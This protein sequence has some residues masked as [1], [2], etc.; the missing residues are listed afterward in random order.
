MDASEDI[1]HDADDYDGDGHGFAS[2]SDDHFAS[3]SDNHFAS[4]SDDGLSLDQL[5]EAFASLLSAGADP[6]VAAA[7]PAVESGEA[8]DL[9]HADVL[10]E[11]AE[12]EDDLCEITPRSIFE[13]MLFVGRA[14]NAPL[15]AKEVSSLMRGVRPDEIVGLVDEL[16]A[17]YE[18]RGCP[19]EI[20]AVDAGYRLVLRPDFEGVRDQVLGRLREARL[21]QAAVDVMAIVA[22]HQ[23]VTSEEVAKL[24]GKPSGAILSQLVRRQLLRIDRVEATATEAPTKERSRKAQYATTR[25][26]LEFFGIAALDELPRP[27]DVERK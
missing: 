25:K 21:S 9:A 17:A 10:A 27:Q 12:A 11:A 5:G 18:E 7:N 1:D 19:Y 8:A 2:P 16:N 22:Y 26:F 24:R 6:Y 3:P 14:N 20:I 4:P 15:T 23:P 13:A